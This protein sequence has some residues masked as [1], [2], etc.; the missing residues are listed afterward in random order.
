MRGT[1]GTRRGAENWRILW[2][3][4][5]A[6]AVALVVL[7]VPSTGGASGATVI[8]DWQMDEAPGARYLIDQGPSGIH[9]QIGT[10]VQSGVAVQG[11]VGHRFSTVAPDTSPLNPERL[12]LVG[13]D[14]RLNPGSGD[15]AVT[16]RLRTTRP[17][18]NVVQKGQSATTGGFIK[19]D[20]DEGRV[21][22]TVIGSAGSAFVRSTQSIANGVWRQ[23][24]CVR[25]VDELVLSV[26]GVVVDRRRA[27]TG[28]IAN[29]WPLTIAGKVSCNQTSVGCDYF[30]GDLDR[31]TLER[32]GDPLASPP[33]TTTT[34]SPGGSSTTAPTTTT[35]AGPT[36]TMPIIVK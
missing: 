6:F 11:S 28:T 29:T 36:T 20:M 7:G 19:I 14:A 34:T 3:L 24:R 5:P 1:L 15:Y 10:S 26:D 35:V 25:T 9:G 21:A 23:V 27:V 30:S 22:C 33:A 16:V 4:A 31:V 12:D 8:A 18:G 2:R 13:H 17:Q 32:S